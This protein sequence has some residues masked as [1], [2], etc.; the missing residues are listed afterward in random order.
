MEFSISFTNDSTQL[1]KI[2]LQ[3]QLNKCF[4]STGL[5]A[6]RGHLGGW[7]GKLGNHNGEPWFWEGSPP[8][9][10]TVKWCGRP[11]H[12]LLGLI[13]SQLSTT[14]QAG[15]SAL[16]VLQRV[17]HRSREQRGGKQKEE[18]L[19]AMC[20]RESNTP[21]PKALVRFLRVCV[22]NHNQSLQVV[23]LRRPLATTKC[24]LRRLCRFGFKSSLGSFL[25]QMEMAE[26]PPNKSANQQQQI[27]NYRQEWD[28]SSAWL[29]AV[30]ESA[31][32]GKLQTLFLKM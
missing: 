12:Q 16:R 21:P 20:C 18:E 30:R 22:Q 8:Q 11:L 3:T 9:A 29:N 7:P 26:A 28:D 2:E 6:T 10:L 17:G 23:L 5:V 14:Q 19:P 31:Q 25:L 24:S 27:Q 1:Y 13:G 15:S 32:I 4:F